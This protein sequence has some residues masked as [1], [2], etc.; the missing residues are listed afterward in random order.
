M[1]AI[2]DDAV[3]FIK[4]LFSGNSGGHDAEHSFRGET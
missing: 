2:T 3:Q 1:S 4:A